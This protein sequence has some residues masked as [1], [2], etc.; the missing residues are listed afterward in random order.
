VATWSR[1]VAVICSAVNLRSSISVGVLDC[2]L[3]AVGVDELEVAGRA[4]ERGESARAATAPLNAA[5]ASARG[6]RGGGTH[7]AAE[8]EGAEPAV[9]LNAVHE[10]IL[11]FTRWLS[12]RSAI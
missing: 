5:P 1:V 8:N 2:G 12:A 3:L 9:S 10:L 7:D 11:R 6:K 4:L